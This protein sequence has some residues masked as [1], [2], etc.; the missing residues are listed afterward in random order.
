MVAKSMKPMKG[1]EN[2]PEAEYAMG[3]P[4]TFFWYNKW[5]ASLTLSPVFNANTSHTFGN[6]THFRNGMVKSDQSI[7]KARQKDKCKRKKEWSIVIVPGEFLM[8]LMGCS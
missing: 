6:R 3:A 7:N 4:H 5:M 2:P 1:S 8:A